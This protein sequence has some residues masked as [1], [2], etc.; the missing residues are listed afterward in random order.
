MRTSTRRGVLA[1]AA[2]TTATLA[3]TACGTTTE[4]AATGATT[5]SRTTTWTCPPR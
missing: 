5:S 3:L 2:L 4:P 1:L